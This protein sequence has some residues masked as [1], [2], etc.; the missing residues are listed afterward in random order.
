MIINRLKTNKKFIFS[1]IVSSAIILMVLIYIVWINFF[2]QP[3]EFHADKGIIDLHHW[4]M[5]QDTN[6]YLAGEWEFYPHELLTPEDDFDEYENIKQYV[7]V[8]GSWE[9]YL[10]K[11]GSVDGS[12]TY[13]VKLKLP[14]DDLYGLK[15]RTIR[16]S[17]RIFM[18]NREIASAGNPS[19]DRANY[20]AE[21]SHRIGFVESENQELILIVH[22]SSYDYM[23]GGITKA[24]EFGRYESILRQDRI[25][26]G[27]DAM[28]ISI[29]FV[30]G[31]YF[32]A[33]YFQRGKGK[34]LLYFSLTSIFISLYLSTL[35]EQLLH[36]L[37]GYSQNIRMRIQ[38]VS[39]MIF[40]ICLLKFM[41]YSFKECSNRKVINIIIGLV[42][43]SMSLAFFTVEGTS[44]ITISF[45]Q[46][47]VSAT[48]FM[49]FMKIF[50]ILIKSIIKKVESLEYILIFTSTMFSCWMA[51]V[52]RVFFEFYLG[53]LMLVLVFTILI[54]IALLMGE[55]LQIDYKNV[56]SLSNKLLEEDKLKDEFLERV[57]HELR[58]PLHVILNATEALIEG[59]KGTINE[60]QQES[61]FFI[62]QEG[63]RLTSLVED[64]LYASQME[65]GEINI[66][67]ATIN[68]HKIVEDV[69]R[70]IHAVIPKNKN[71]QLINNIPEDF[72]QLK[73][74]HG[75]FIQVIY[76][77][78]NN[79]IKY[80]KSGEIAISAS[81][82]DEYAIFRVRDTGIGIKEEDLESI[83]NKFYRKL[84]N[85]I[86][87]PELGLGLGLSVVKQLVEVQGGT[88]DVESTY[89]K[90]S[91]FLF[92]IPLQEI[93]EDIIEVAQ[94]E[95]SITEQEMAYSM[96]RATLLIV[97]DEISN[98]KVL[99]DILIEAQYNLIFAH[100]GREAIKILEDHQVDLIILDLMLPDISGDIACQQIRKKYSMVELPII[101]LTASGRIKDFKNTFECGANDFLKKPADSV[102]LRSRIKSLL[103]MKSSVEEG[104]RKEFE[105]FY[106]QISP[107][108]LYN[109]LNTIIGLSYTDMSK[110]REALNNLSIYFRGK[111]DVYQ[112]RSLISLESE[113]ELVT[114]YLEIEHLRYSHRLK[115]LFD[116]DE[117]IHLMIPPLTI[118]PLVENSIRH[119]IAVK[120]DGGYVKIAVKKN[121]DVVIITIE[122][123]GVGMSAERKEA[124]LS[125]HHESLGFKN[126]K[127]KIKR[128]KG[129][130]LELESEE[131]KGCV[132]TIR[133]PVK[134]TI[135]FV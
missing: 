88:V 34:E 114:A 99:A 46:Y 97:D 96:D 32:F 105:Y 14:R 41:Y 133:I 7:E 80:T 60:K 56:Q 100:N 81:I 106:S 12:G 134:N 83:F 129:A 38:L 4:D 17:N 61:L 62:I 26:R 18:K 1:I 20:V 98:Q 93:Q 76:N 107:H 82:Q 108:F 65:D 103:L 128:I 73:A 85:D 28:A 37:I 2:D 31:L 19:M 48:T 104:L 23:S 57:S 77:L 132:I 123:D 131:S 25:V 43:L 117:N 22:V 101:M 87:Q 35:N 121:I 109:T 63:K 30:L 36:S 124:L 91:T 113:L 59:K 70:E 16:T 58:T 86:V 116:I 66:R 53:N 3:H 72:P 120:K 10:N 9:T 45:S 42:V 5:H 74:D 118:Q 29:A 24:I 44:F 27:I 71:I 69:L 47:F 130:S 78:V 92:T 79:S 75:K 111:L 13:R 135:K 8:P 55:K 67:L 84:D 21:E 125:G 49:A 95:Q 115:I 112:N 51:M 68:S 126:V 52:L 94:L 119:G 50:F 6:I 39:I 89:G 54:S 33:T 127:E 110:A 102:E 15:T 64:L 90:G 11:D 122:D 40:T